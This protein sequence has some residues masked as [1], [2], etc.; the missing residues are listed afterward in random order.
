MPE[1][2]AASK[3]PVPVALNQFQTEDRGFLGWLR[4][5]RRN[6]KRQIVQVRDRKLWIGDLARRSVP[7]RHRGEC[8]FRSI[9]QILAGLRAPCEDDHAQDDPRHPCSGD[10][11]NG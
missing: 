10:L 5:N 4:D 7:V 9:H 3:M 2:M 11:R 6:A 1:R 8:F